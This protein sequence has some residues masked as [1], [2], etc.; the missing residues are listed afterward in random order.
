MTKTST[1]VLLAKAA[2]TI[3]VERQ[4][5]RRACNRL[6]LRDRRPD[7]QR[8][9]PAEVVRLFARTRQF[10]GYLYPKNINSLDS[11]LRAANE[12]ASASKE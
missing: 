1:A 10:S 5:L 11:L 4:T 6:G 3:G 8:V 12:L 2:K 7:G 9:I